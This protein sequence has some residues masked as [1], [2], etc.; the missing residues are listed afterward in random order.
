MNANIKKSLCVVLCGFI[1]LI[2]DGFLNTHGSLG[3]ILA[4]AS[5]TYFVLE[6]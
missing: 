1:G 4:I 3:L 6:K 5:A 2:C